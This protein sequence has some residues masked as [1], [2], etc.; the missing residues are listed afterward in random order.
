YLYAN[1]NK[2]TNFEVL[3]TLTNL[4]N[5]EISNTGIKDI[6]ILAPLTQLEHLSLWFNDQIEDFTTLSTLSTLKYLN[7]QKTNFKDSDIVHIASKTGYPPSSG[8]PFQPK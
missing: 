3:S 2:F 7:I 4:K 8:Y 5:L 1:T 6:T